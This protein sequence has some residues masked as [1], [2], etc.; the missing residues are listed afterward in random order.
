ML[1]SSLLAASQTES[2]GL[3]SKVQWHDE[4]SMRKIKGGCFSLLVS[5]FYRHWEGEVKE[6]LY[7]ER[8]V[9]S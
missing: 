9:G 4:I 3:R 2:P 8:W 1:F 7:F 6:R 5:M